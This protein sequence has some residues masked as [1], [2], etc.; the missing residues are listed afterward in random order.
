MVDKTRISDHLELS[1]RFSGLM[2]SGAARNSCVFGV[3]GVFEE[4]QP[5]QVGHSRL[6]VVRFGSG[7]SR[8]SSHG[9]LAAVTKVL[10]GERSFNSLNAVPVAR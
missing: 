2:A 7:E 6:K 8:S 9:T 10:E 5:G 1:G 3:D 4:A